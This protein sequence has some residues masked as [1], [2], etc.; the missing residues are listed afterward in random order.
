MQYYE[1][2]TIPVSGRQQF[3]SS[4]DGAVSDSVFLDLSSADEGVP[5]RSGDEWL[6]QAT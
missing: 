5:E 6:L 2:Q 4:S 1:G 3:S